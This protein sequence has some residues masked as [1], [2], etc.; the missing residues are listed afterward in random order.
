MI[1]PA[2]NDKARLVSSFTDYEVQKFI[3]GKWV[4]VKTF[5]GMSNGSAWTQARQWLRMVQKGLT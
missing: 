5:D 2:S 4:T 1:D 3:D